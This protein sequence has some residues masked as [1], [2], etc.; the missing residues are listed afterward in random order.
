MC[1]YFQ[2]P[3]CKKQCWLWTWICWCVQNHH[4]FRRR[5][6]I[7]CDGGGYETPCASGSKRGKSHARQQQLPTS[8]KSP[9]KDVLRGQLC[10]CRSRHF[11]SV[12]GFG[13]ATIVTSFLTTLLLAETAAF[14]RHHLLEPLGPG[15]VRHLRSTT[16]RHTRHGCGEGAVRDGGGRPTPSCL[17]R[18]GSSP[19]GHGNIKEKHRTSPYEPL[20]TRWLL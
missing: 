19:N 6:W 9:A 4:R 17:S 1:L 20:N 16:E 10:P 8:S 13:A 3:V 7:P 2:S 5:R 11:T 14:C 15:T 18:N 12:S